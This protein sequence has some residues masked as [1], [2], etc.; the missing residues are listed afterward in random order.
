MITTNFKLSPHE[1]SFSVKC[2]NTVLIVLNGLLSFVN[3]KHNILHTLTQ[4]KKIYRK[5]KR[6]RKRITQNLVTKTIK[7]LNINKKI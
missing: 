1:L 6:K 3:I 2:D 5:V 4:I 7:H